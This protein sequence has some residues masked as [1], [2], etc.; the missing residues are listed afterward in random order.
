MA[1]Q[2]L[3]GQGLLIIE[4]S[5][6]HSGTPHPVELL[7]T[8]DQPVAETSTGQHTTLTREEYP[9]SGGIR[10]RNPSEREAADPRQYKQI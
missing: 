8:S 2:P 4:A 7:C 10:T 3:V 1:Q 6:S 5:R 9:C